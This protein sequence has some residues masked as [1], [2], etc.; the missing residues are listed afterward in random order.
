MGNP[1]TQIQIQIVTVRINEEKTHISR[2]INPRRVQLNFGVNV[3]TGRLL[4]YNFLRRLS[5][6]TMTVRATIGEV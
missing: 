1:I 6:T 5:S 4:S 2:R 3:G